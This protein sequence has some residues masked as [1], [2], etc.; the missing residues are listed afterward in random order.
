LEADKFEKFSILNINAPIYCN[1][2]ANVDS[3]LA[4][5][6]AHGNEYLNRFK[7]NE[8]LLG[9]IIRKM[10]FTIGIGTS[11]FLEIAK[12]R[13]F[14]SLWSTIVN[15]YIPDTKVNTKVHAI[16][17]NRYYSN[18][19]IYNN[20]LRATST[21]MSAVIGGCDSLTL[22][23]FNFNSIDNDEF[24]LRISK[25]IQ[26]VIQEESYLHKVKNPSS[27]SYYIESMVDL[28]KNNSWVSFLDLEKN[29]GL[30]SSLFSGQIQNQ[31][32]KEHSFKV[33]ELK[34]ER[35]IMIGV[36]KFINSNDS[37]IEN[38]ELKEKLTDSLIKPLT[39]RRLSSAYE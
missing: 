22:L 6:I 17:A 19:D 10:E 25:N 29:G 26:L 12:L 32:Q 33:S 37:T 7:D 15:Q 34:E 3:Q 2:G 20:L 36:N 38:I 11:Y 31:I 28:L 9:K 5:A 18:K 16:N 39:H 30:L 35:N 27:G 23:P 21:G 24:G 8:Y 13:A 4:F 1:S 14:R